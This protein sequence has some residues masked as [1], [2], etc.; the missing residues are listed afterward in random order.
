ME[1]TNEHDA[2]TVDQFCHRNNLSRSKFYEL[3]KEGL[4][5]QLFYIGTS[6]RISVESATKWRRQMEDKTQ[7]GAA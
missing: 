2:Y 1:S 6:P 5:P 4:A 7:R 3:R